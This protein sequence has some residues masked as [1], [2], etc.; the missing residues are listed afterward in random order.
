MRKRQDYDFDAEMEELRRKI[1][2]LDRNSDRIQRT[3]SYDA[4]RLSQRRAVC[5][6]CHGTGFITEM[7]KVSNILTPWPPFRYEKQTVRCPEC[8]RGY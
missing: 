1:R 8:N 5:W 6:K 4:S 7:V 3:T 2:D